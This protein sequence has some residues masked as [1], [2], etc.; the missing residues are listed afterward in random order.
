VA[1]RGSEAHQV[2]AYEILDARSRMAA[3]RRQRNGRLRFYREMNRPVK[4]GAQRV[5]LSM[6]MERDALLGVF[7]VLSLYG[8]LR[9]FGGHGRN[10]D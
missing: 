9:G 3:D 10:L 2:V 1:V 8:L 5:R 4:P 7:S 6:E